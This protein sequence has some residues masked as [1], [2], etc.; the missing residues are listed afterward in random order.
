MATDSSNQTNQSQH[1]TTQVSQ[2]INVND[3][4]NNHIASELQSPN[5]KLA[6]WMA[7]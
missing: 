3:F 2:L 5:G 7:E 4:F 6:V 1:G